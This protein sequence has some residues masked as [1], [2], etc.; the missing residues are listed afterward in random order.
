MHM[1]SS[2]GDIALVIVDG[3]GD[4]SLSKINKRPDIYTGETRFVKYNHFVTTLKI[5]PCV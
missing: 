2:N 3:E 5:N 4:W 1:Q